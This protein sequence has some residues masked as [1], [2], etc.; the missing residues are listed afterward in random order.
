[1]T[2]LKQQTLMVLLG[3]VLLTLIFGGLLSLA[4]NLSL[5]QLQE[6]PDLIVPSLEADRYDSVS[7]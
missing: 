1:M 2:S 6:Q 5:K 3:S 4:V 7:P